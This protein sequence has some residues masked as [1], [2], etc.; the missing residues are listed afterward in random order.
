MVSSMVTEFLFIQKE[1]NTRATGRETKRT[2]K[3]SSLTLMD[4]I[5]MDTGETIP[6][7]GKGLSIA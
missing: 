6:N 4:H 1:T 3:V 2:V 5:T 7:M